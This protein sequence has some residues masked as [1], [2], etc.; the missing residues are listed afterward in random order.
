M[1][2]R[3]RSGT[4]I[5]KPQEQRDMWNVGRISSQCNCT[6]CECMGENIIFIQADSWR[7]F[8]CLIDQIALPDCYKKQ[9]KKKFTLA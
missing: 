8:C 3:G 5:R 1:G 9:N 7:T 4:F 6:M 2:Q